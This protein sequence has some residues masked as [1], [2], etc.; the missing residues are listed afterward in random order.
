M[1]KS[2]NEALQSQELQIQVILC[3]FIPTRDPFHIVILYTVNTN[4]L[5]IAALSQLS[6]MPVAN[7]AFATN[8]HVCHKN[9]KQSTLT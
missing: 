5:V 6:A 1:N 9:Q 7:H 2:H 3:W 4:I 8:G